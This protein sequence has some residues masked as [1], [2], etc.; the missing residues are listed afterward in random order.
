MAKQHGE[1]IV[2]QQIAA[3]YAGKWPPDLSAIAGLGF[4][5][6]SSSKTAVVARKVESTSITGKP[7]TFTE[8]EIRHD[9]IRLS[10]SLPKNSSKQLRALPAAILLFRTLAL[11]PNLSAD[12]QSLSKLVLPPLEASAQVAD[13]PYGLLS[14]KCA[15]AQSDLKELS[16]KNKHA[17]RMAEEGVASLAEME[18]RATA[19]QERV[20]FL[21]AVPET[22]LREAVLDWVVSHRGSFNAAAFSKSAG[23]PV[24]RCEEGLD[25]LL[26]D[27]TISKINGNSLAAHSHT[28]RIFQVQNAI[29]LFTHPLFRKAKSSLPVQ[30]RKG[31]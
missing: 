28:G 29:R 18:K 7:H 8:I 31:L 27:G 25:L 24:S 22:A 15:D 20:R 6:L 19:F 9:S 17:L 11:L 3:K 4:D 26:K 21:E 5:F 16:V 10:H 12:T 13:A 14:K 2:V 23:I 30:L 1:Q